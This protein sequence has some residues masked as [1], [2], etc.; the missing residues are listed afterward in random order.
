MA[1]SAA[2]SDL[3]MPMLVE[4]LREKMERGATTL[5]SP[6]FWSVAIAARWRRR[7]SWD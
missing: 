5:S 6:L 4:S 2:C 7:T 3:V 1:R